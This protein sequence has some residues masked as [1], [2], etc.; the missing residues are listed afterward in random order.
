MFKCR[1]PLLRL[2]PALHLLAL[3]PLLYALE[4]YHQ[5]LPRSPDFLTSP[6]ISAVALA[7]SPPLWFFGF[8][9]YTDVPGVVFVLSSFVMQANGQ[10]WLAA[11]VRGALCS[12]SMMTDRGVTTDWPVEFILSSN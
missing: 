1:L 5:R 8:L 3:P 10:N 12:L 7:A 4:T 2:V 11:L 9:Y 6:S